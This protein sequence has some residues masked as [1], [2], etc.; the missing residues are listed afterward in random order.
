VRPFYERAH[1]LVVPVFEGSG[2]RLKIVE[3]AML[4]RPVISTALGAEGLPVRAGHHYVGAETAEEWVAAVER[5]R[6]DELAGMAT[7]ARAAVEH[8]TWPRLTAE[9]AEKYRQLVSEREEHDYRPV[10]SA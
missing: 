8:L 6:R 9:L 7:A 3:A 10:T 5:V 1:A 4:G 2:T